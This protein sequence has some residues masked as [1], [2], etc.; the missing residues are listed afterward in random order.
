MSNAPFH[1]FTVADGWDNV[2]TL[3]P[4]AAR[5]ATDI[6]GEVALERE[7]DLEIKTSGAPEVRG[8]LFPLFEDSLGRSSLLRLG[9]WHM[10][11]SHLP[12]KKNQPP[13]Q[14]RTGPLRPRRGSL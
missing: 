5:R 4:G 6:P 14:E 9:G 8:P 2:D 3:F 13:T 12:R 10:A 11:P 1:A 7:G